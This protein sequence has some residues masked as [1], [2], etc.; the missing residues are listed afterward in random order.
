MFKERSPANYRS[1]VDDVILLITDGVPNGLQNSEKITKQY[2]QDLKDRNI[3]IITVGVGSLA[4][5]YE[6]VLIDL[7]TSDNHFV[8]VTGFHMLE[9]LLD[10]L[11]TKSCRPGAGKLSS[12]IAAS[13]TSRNH[14]QN[15][16]LISIISKTE[17]IRFS[18]PLN[19]Q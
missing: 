17:V 8:Y 10:K 2:A 9:S 16:C 18:G 3:V 5:R 7:A 11:V 15:C 1:D 19:D 14:S 12:A 13:F 6:H 4:K